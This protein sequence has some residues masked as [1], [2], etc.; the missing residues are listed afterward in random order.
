MSMFKHSGPRTQR[1]VKYLKRRSR[2]PRP[3]RPQLDCKSYPTLFRKQAIVFTDT[4]DFTIRTARDGILHCLMLFEEISNAAI[5]AIGK[6][7]GDVVK[8]EGDSLLL[9]FPDVGDACRGVIALDAALTRMNRGRPA[10][11]QLSFSYGIGYGDV[12]DL[13]DDVFGL[14]VNLASKIGE[15]LAKP[16]EVLLTPAAAAALDAKLLKRVVSYK[17]VAFE[18]SAIPIQRLK[19]PG[20][21]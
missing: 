3:G 16:G 8:M 13:E 19:L 2:T 20:R 6:E 14:E 11:E 18:K 15:D 12:L 17:I 1:L 5:K 21:R 10:N 4:A 7:K 9:R